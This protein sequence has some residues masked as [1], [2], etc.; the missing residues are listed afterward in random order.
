MAGE[1]VFTGVVIPMA[2]SK[3]TSDVIVEGGNNHASNI[4]GSP[5]EQDL[6]LAF[7][8]IQ[9][10]YDNW[11][12]V[13]WTGNAATVNGKTIAANVPSGAV[14][15]DTTYS[16]SGAYGSNNDTWVTTLTPSS[17]SAT[18][19]T[20]PTA[21]T[22]V[23]GITKLSSSTS[24]TSTTLA[25][26][27][28]AVKS[29]YD[30]AAGKSAVSF[31][32][33]LTTGSEVGKITI[34][35]TETTLYAPAGTGN[36]RV[37]QNISTANK[38]FPLLLSYYE[39]SSSTTTAQEANRASGIYA[40]P[41]TGTVTAT[42]FVGTVNG[43]SIGKAVPADAVFT[44]TTYSA[45]TGLTLATGNVFNHTDS[46]T[47]IT[48]AGLYKVKYNATGHITGTT[49]VE[50]AD[51]TALGIPGSD[52]TYTFAEGSTNGAF[53]VTPSGG[54]AQTVSIHGLGSAAYAAT[55]AF[56]PAVP[57]GVTSFLDANMVVDTKYLPSFVDDVIEG[58]YSHA[59]GKFYD[60][61]VVD[62]YLYS[63]TFYEDS[64]HTTPI[65]PN[66][67][68]F[69]IDK[70]NSNASY[71]WSGTAYV[72][73]ATTSHEIAGESD[74][75]YLDLSVTPAEGYRWGGSAFV[76][77]KQPTISAVANVVYKSNGTITVSY[78]DGTASTDVTVYSHPTTSGN[79]HI[80][81]GGTVDQILRNSASGTGE[82]KW[83][84]DLTS[85]N[86]DFVGATAN[87]AG[88]HGLVPAPATGQNSRHY[89]RGDGTWSDDP[90]TTADTLVL[91]VVAGS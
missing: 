86:H 57:D 12:S 55:T 60:W 9:N 25:A 79:K 19:S 33:T 4:S 34:D 3:A 59:T 2:F 74:K 61:P 67:N 71:T 32:Q 31:S 78:T 1:K 45:G 23:Y 43:Y 26:T 83:I 41:S 69:Y 89:L 54:S 16:L 21:T 91:H 51:I 48:T 28:S 5:T 85:T 44:D 87:A 56:V 70:G 24:S 11:H 65:T 36:D 10:W 18:T 68:T 7:G 29:A 39:T 52:T 13:V 27:P 90:V 46:V 35:G 77:L 75:I 82:W 17:G 22:S 6:A 42:N 84:K 38:N 72:S 49:A 20:V 53:T 63:G 47:A 80:P 76:S 40:N 14:F 88:N 81:S 66:T 37:T 62:G 58:Y 64:D 8:K 30:L 73:T 15:T 50:K